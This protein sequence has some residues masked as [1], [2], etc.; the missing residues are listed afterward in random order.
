MSIIDVRNYIL[1]NL[2]QPSNNKSIEE[3]DIYKHLE[4]YYL[5]NT[6][7]KD[8]LQNHSDKVEIEEQQNFDTMAHD[9]VNSQDAAEDEQLVQSP[10]SNNGAQTGKI[11]C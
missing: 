6:N 1:D 11:D 3:L 10:P 7:S 8:T 2:S 5:R 4:G 9:E